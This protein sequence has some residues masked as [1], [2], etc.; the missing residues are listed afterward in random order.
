MRRLWQRGDRSASP[1]PHRQ[2]TKKKGQRLG[3]LGSRGAGLSIGGM[4]DYLTWICR[5]AVGRPLALTLSVA[6]PPF[7][8]PCT[9]TTS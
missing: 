8:P 9:S 3:S 5:L 4:V 1:F 2:R 7:V 6:L